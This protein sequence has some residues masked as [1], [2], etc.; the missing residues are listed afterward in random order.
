VA[1]AALATATAAAAELGWVEL[2]VLGWVEEVVFC[3]DATD[4]VAL[5][6]SGSAFTLVALALQVGC[7]DARA[8]G[9]GGGFV[10]GRWV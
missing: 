2:L 9:A 7:L 8:L 4:V 5:G 6:P 3:C 10:G 1:S